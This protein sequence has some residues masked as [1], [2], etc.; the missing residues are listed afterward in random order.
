[1]GCEF[2]VL[3]ATSHTVVPERDHSDPSKIIYQAESPDEGALTYAAKCLGFNFHSRTS[4]GIVVNELGKGDVS[5]E[6]LNVNKFNS[7]RKRMSVC[8]RRPDKS[9][10]C[11]CKGADNV[12]FARLD[13]KQDGLNK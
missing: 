2:L 6:V 9:I 4:E 10:V 13:K 3:L 12:M 7:D 5:Y 1:M 8:I 11:Y